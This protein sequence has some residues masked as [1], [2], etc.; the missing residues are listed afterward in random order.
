[1]DILVKVADDICVAHGTIT[2]KPA[3]DMYFIEEQ[4]THIQYISLYNLYND[5][6][7][8]ADYVDKK[9]KYI[10]GTGFELNENYVEP[11]YLE[12]YVRENRDRIKDLESDMAT[13][14]SNIQTLQSQ[15]STAISEIQS[16]QSRVTALENA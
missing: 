9:Y 11:I 4:Q 5:V 7:L 16:L 10:D 2:T 8:P 12:V 15:M 14:I 13:A 1:M 6:T 3:R